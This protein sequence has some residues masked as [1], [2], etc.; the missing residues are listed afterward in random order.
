MLSFLSP[1]PFNIA[2]DSIL[3]VMCER[4]V[5]YLNPFWLNQARNAQCSSLVVA[6]GNRTKYKYEDGRGV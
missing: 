4:S 2:L 5:F 1:K 6:I 3:M